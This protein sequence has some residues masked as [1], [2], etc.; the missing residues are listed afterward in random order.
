MRQTRLV[1]AFALF[2]ASLGVSAAAPDR[3]VLPDG[4]VPEHYTLSI[5]PDM[6]HLS[7]TGTVRIDITVRQATKTLTLDAADLTFKRV[8]LQSTPVSP[9]VSYDAGQETATIRFKHALKPGKHS[10]FISYA[11]R[12][13]Q[14]PAGLFALDYDTPTGSKRALFTQFENADARRFMPCWDEP[15]IKTT[16]TL[17]AIVPASL[18]AVSNMPVARV[19]KL[20]HGLR[21]VTFAETPK[22]SSY[23]LF[24]G[25]GDFERVSRK[26]GGVDVGVV[27]RRGEAGQA[28]FALDSA[29]QLLPYY[30][31]YFGVKYPLPKLDFVAGPGQSESF[32]AM[33]NWGAIFLFEESLLVDPRISTQ[34]DRRNV[35]LDLTHEM[36]HQW[37]GDLVTMQWWDDLWLNEGFASW[38]EAKTAE[39]FHPG[40]KPWLSYLTAR[41]YMSVREGAMDVDAVAGTHPIITPIRDVREADQVFDSITYEKGESV[42]R[43]LEEYV[44]PDAFRDGVRAYIKAHAYGSTVTDDLWS[45]LDKVTR[46]PVTQVAH[47]FTLQAGVPLIRSTRA[48]DGL[49][50]SQDRYAM[51]DSGKPGGSWQVPVTVASIDGTSPWHGLVSRGT[52]VTVPLAAGETAVVNYGQVGYFRTLY[53]DAGFDAL[54]AHYAALA[55]ADRIGLLNDSLALGEAGYAP[56]DRFLSL[57]RSAAGDTEPLALENLVEQLGALD[58][59]YRDLPSQAGYRAYARTLLHPLFLKLGWVP[60]PGE[61]GNVTQLRTDLL[62]TLGRMDDPDVLAGARGRFTAYLKDPASLSGDL[63]H[64]VLETVARHADAATWD[65]LQALAKVAGSNV[66]KRELYVLLGA[67]EDPAVARRALD[68]S[69]GAAAPA[70]ARPALLNAVSVLHPE[71]ALDFLMAHSDSFDTLLEPDARAVFAPR[72]AAGSNDAA[73][74]QKLETYAAEHI[75][76][77]DRI[78]VQRAEAQIRR[79]IL[80]RTER[81]PEVD[82][83]LAQPPR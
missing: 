27:V 1:P 58:V 79:N 68:L 34:I 43:M 31:D 74:L 2:A 10:L 46:L 38:M 47:D 28:G 59:Y 44:G 4:V 3:I 55:P 37:F 21:N 41:G 6:A 42:V 77:D 75:P 51:D 66:E 29:A 24:F 17:S 52:P 81:L 7:F 39:R 36:A 53:D 78:S 54:A 11:G 73:T 62:L 9:T 18:M 60:Q 30:E 23:L 16:Y 83:W 26:V 61:D 49:H 5:T 82:A 70:T 57:T 25:L 20:K 32:D 65:E 76:A 72:L 64:V 50:L 71:M 67:A 45:A 35:F 13:N 48:P 33:E 19:R 14:H 22:M 69:L 56:L 63:R 40:W 15:G 80:M 8:A 12:I